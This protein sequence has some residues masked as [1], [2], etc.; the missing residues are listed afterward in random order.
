M[1]FPRPFLLNNL[2]TSPDYSAALIGEGNFCRVNKRFDTQYGLNIA[3]KSFE[4]CLVQ[5]LHKLDDLKMEKH[6]LARLDHPHI[7]K[8]YFTWSDASHAYIG[9]ELCSSGELWNQCRRVG[10][11]EVRACVYFKQIISGIAYMHRMGIVHRDLK[12]E[13]VFLTCDGQVAKI[14]D[15]GS[16]RDLFNPALKGAGN[17]STS[18]RCSIA[19]EHYVGSPNFLS[20]EAIENKENDEL[21]DIWSLGCL[22]YQVLV[23]L[24]PF[25]AGSEYLVYVRARALD[26]HFPP[27]LS[28]ASIDLV[29][30]IIK[31]NRADRPSLARIDS[32]SF[33]SD[34]PIFVE[35]L[36]ATDL[37][38]RDVARD[39][40]VEITDQFIESFSSAEAVRM[41]LR[42]VRTVRY[43]EQLA[44]PGAGT[45]MLQ[46]LN[47]N[48][49]ESS[50]KSSSCSDTDL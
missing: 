42:H 11:P 7:V 35:E 3:L 13:N 24:A 19:M 47:F 15:F 20:P 4:T 31:L 49:E 27:G 12:A 37:R 30:T 32:H 43:W 26:L 18:S 28:D 39:E 45:D 16:S 36:N 6:A 34:S 10:E 40:S 21:S 29:K 5:R 46:H 1:S 25:V 44:R 8:L 2:D 17:K 33:F 50:D 9:T 48:A 23:G 41:R 22:F 38:I 14:G